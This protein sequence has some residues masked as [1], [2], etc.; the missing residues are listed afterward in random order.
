[1]LYALIHENVTEEINENVSD[2][3]KSRKFDTIVAKV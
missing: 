1:M 3:E 2:E